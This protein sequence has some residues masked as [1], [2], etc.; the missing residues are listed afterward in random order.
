MSKPE[1]AVSKNFF[2]HA[3]KHGFINSIL[4]KEWNMEKKNPCDTILMLLKALITRIMT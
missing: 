4:M 2:F 3:Y 1:K